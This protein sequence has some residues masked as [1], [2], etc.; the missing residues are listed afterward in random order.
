MSTLFGGLCCVG[1]IH[2]IDDVAGVRRQG[3]ALLLGPS[4]DGDRFQS[5]KRRVFK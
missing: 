2:P 5:P 3:L 4:E 1:F